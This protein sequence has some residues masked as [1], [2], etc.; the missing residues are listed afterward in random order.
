MTIATSPRR[1]L[2]ISA[3][4]A[5]LVLA[6]C[7]DGED[8]PR[9]D[10]IE[11]SGSASGSSGS[12][13]ASG[14]VSS[15][16]AA[17]PSG[18]EY[19][20]AS[21]VDAYFAVGLDLRDIRAVMAPASQGQPVDWA[22]ATAIYQEG[23]N[24][25]RADGTVRSLASIPNDDVQ[26]MFANGASVYGRPNFIDAMIRDGLNGTGRGQGL[27]DDSRRQIVD[28]GI[29]MLMYGKALQEL[30][31]ARTRI[32]Q[33]NLDNNSGAPHAVDEAWGVIAGAPDNNGAR[34]HALLQTATS[35]E[36]NFKL[37]GKIR[38]PIEAAF[39]AAQKAAQA[40]DL[41]AF[42]KTHGEIKGYLNSI[43]YLASLRYAKTL[44]GDTEATA[45]ETH[46][47]EGWAFSQTIRA[48]VASGSASAAKTVE[49]TYNRSATGAF[50]AS[51]TAAIY[52]ALNESAVIQA[53]GIPAALVVTTPPAQ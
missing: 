37:E 24:Q 41:A 10:V 49:D 48:T 30:S 16:P 29:Q 32:E 47:A 20:T 7:G 25:T 44:E 11:D 3:V 31:A 22:Q 46:L 51:I 36:S 53:L 35:R 26:K 23:K 4:M 6:G 28:K 18:A 19:A 12:V 14:P 50:S 39:V 17:S 9:V 21:N 52:S 5:A 1:L 42:D 38:Q 15:L 13:S 8:R 2:V 27:S 43:F 45:R 33:K 34:P 40:G